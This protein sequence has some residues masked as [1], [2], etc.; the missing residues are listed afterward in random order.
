MI[1]VSQ[2]SGRQ[3]A[4]VGLGKSGLATATA[5]SRSG[6]RVWAWD[7]S[8]VARVR[9]TQ[10]GITLQLP[11]VE[12]LRGCAALILS[13][14]IPLTHPAP[15]PVAQLAREAGCPIIGDIELLYGAQKTA[16]YLGITGTNGKSTTTALIGHILQTAGEP[17]QVGGNLGAPALGL[18]PLTAGGTYVLELSSYQLDLLAEA[19]FN[20]AVLINITPDH[21]NRHGGMAGYVK[22]KTRIFEGGAAADAAIVG[23]DDSHS[24]AIYEELRE[25]SSRRVIGISAQKAISGGVY[26][27][28]G[29]LFDALDGEAEPVR[30]LTDIPTLPGLHNWQNVA[31]AYAAVRA[32]GLPRGVIAEALGTYPGLAHRMERAGVVDGILY[33]NDSKATNAD[34]AIRAMACYDD[35]YWI[36]GGLAKEGGLSGV[37]PFLPRVRRAFL[38]GDATESFA[39]YLEGKVPYTRCGTLETAVDRAREAAVTEHVE[40]AVVLLSP[41]CA[42]FDQFPNFEIRGDSFKKLVAALPG[43]RENA[44]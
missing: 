17:V 32:L 14:G 7:D 19:V 9:A 31:A 40:G 29:T 5:L 3:V 39:E 35:I 13:P 20:V 6:A 27:T 16:R 36:I 15:H 12:R 42:S 10:E 24:V 43:E 18:D 21:L 4:V 37:D 38:I 28:N 44:A 30:S 22:A 23:M 2:F 11:D 41:A 25:T 8:E 1:P 34:A 26:V 33:V